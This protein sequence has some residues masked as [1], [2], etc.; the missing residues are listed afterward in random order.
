MLNN[1]RLILL[2]SLF[3]FIFPVHFVFADDDD[4]VLVEGGS[5]V[6]GS[7]IYERGR[8]SG[9]IQRRVRVNPFFMAKYQVTQEE[10]EE[11]MGGN[12]SVFRGENLPVESVSWFDA[13]EYCNR[14]S[15]LEGLTPVYTIDILRVD[16]GNLNNNSRWL[17][18]WN[19]RANGYRLPTE[20]EWEYAAKGGDESPGDFIFSG[21]NNQNEV[22]WFSRNSGASTHPVGTKESNGLGL[23]DMSG[24]V[25]EW[26]W[27][28]Y[29]DYIHAA[30]NNP[31]GAYSGSHRVIRGGSCYDSAGYVRSS[32]RYFCIPANRSIGVGFR[33]VRSALPENWND[34]LLVP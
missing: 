10:Y 9:E 31:I 14:R 3:T 12:P 16:L 18:T 8:N 1:F 5:F 26:C 32:F 4:F 28:W 6:M 11:V 34:T 20:A 24:N 19:R 23:Y 27:D 7:P 22:A 30:R 29:G 15:Q 2:F 25:W 17:V 21:S 33:I 13:I